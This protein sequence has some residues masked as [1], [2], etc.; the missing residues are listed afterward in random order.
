LTRDAAQRHK[1]LGPGPDGG[2]G[3]LQLA[4]VFRGNIDIFCQVKRMTPPAP[5]RRARM[6]SGALLGR[7]QAAAP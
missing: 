4:D 1:C 6:A 5:A 7:K 2:F 3:K